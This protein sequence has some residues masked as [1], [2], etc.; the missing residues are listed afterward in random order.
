MK[1]IV[2]DANEALYDEPSFWFN[3]VFMPVCNGRPKPTNI[4][5]KT[6]MIYHRLYLYVFTTL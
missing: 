4:P 3:F 5:S 6:N 1:A 2:N